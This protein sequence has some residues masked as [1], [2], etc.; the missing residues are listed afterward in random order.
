MPRTKKE[1]K[2]SDT[3]GDKKRFGLS[4][5]ATKPTKPKREVKSKENK[6]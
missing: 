6:K 5:L 4:K 2:L 1:E 3:K